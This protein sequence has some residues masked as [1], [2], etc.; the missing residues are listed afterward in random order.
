MVHDCIDIKGFG[1]KS[2][3]LFLKTDCVCLFGCVGEWVGLQLGSDRNYTLDHDLA[4]VTCNFRC[5]WWT[6]CCLIC[7]AIRSGLYRSNRSPS[8]SDLLQIRLKQVEKAQIRC[9]E[10]SPDS[11]STY[12]YYI[13]P[14]TSVEIYD[15]RG[16]DQ[17][18]RINKIHVCFMDRSAQY[19]GIKQ[20]Y[21]TT[22][23]K[24]YSGVAIRNV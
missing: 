12:S 4:S 6:K 10:C 19:I 17:W 15:L 9:T 14:P 13:S 20:K 7:Q 11:L 23:I 16:N 5:A 8:G 21:T 1:V 2:F 22:T 24:P 3:L 18:W